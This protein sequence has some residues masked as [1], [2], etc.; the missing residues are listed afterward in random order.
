MAQ[1]AEMALQLGGMSAGDAQ[2]FCQTV[3]WTSTLVLGVPRGTSY[4]TVDLDGVQGT[5]IDLPRRR[6]G[7]A[8]PPRYALLWVRNGVIYALSGEG[9]SADAVLLAESLN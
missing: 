6:D 4:Q 8:G 1:L 7:R 5:L 2:A 3:D 9:S